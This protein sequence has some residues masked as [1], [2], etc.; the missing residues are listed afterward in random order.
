[1]ER[2]WQK[3]KPEA[4]TQSKD[5]EKAEVVMFKHKK[6]RVHRAMEPPPPHTTTF[7]IHR[8]IPQ[9]TTIER[10]HSLPVQTQCAQGEI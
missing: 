1:M 7:T 6:T 10:P 2:R 3:T 9:H 4:T 8:Q 5:N